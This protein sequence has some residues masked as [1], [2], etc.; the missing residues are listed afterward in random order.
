VAT[1]KIKG[2]KKKRGGR[3]TTTKKLDKPWEQET[4][5]EKKNRPQ[6][7]QGKVRA[8]PVGTMRNSSKLL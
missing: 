5:G 6:G 3:D 8:G 4:W 1:K 7:E 2:V